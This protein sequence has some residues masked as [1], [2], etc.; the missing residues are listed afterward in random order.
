MY[1]FGFFLKK[2]ID[3]L[4]TENL[5]NEVRIIREDWQLLEIYR[6]KMGRIG[7]PFL[8]NK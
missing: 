4:V 3:I 6:K 7:K 8:E 2:I 1:Y 5:P